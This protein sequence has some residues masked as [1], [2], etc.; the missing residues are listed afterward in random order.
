LILTEPP[1]AMGEISTANA[2]VDF[3]L[4]EPPRDKGEASS[5]ACCLAKRASRCSLI[6]RAKASPGSSYFVGTVAGFT[7]LASSL[8]G[9][10]LA[11]RF[12]GNFFFG[13]LTLHSSSSTDMLVSSA[14]DLN[15]T[16]VA[17]FKIGAF[18]AAGLSLTV[19][20]LDFVGANELSDLGSGIFLA[21]IIFSLSNC[22]V[23]RGLRLDFS[24]DATRCASAAWSMASMASSSSSRASTESSILETGLAGDRDVMIS[25]KES[26]SE[27][28]AAALS[29]AEAFSTSS[30]VF[31]ISLLVL[32]MT[33][34][35]FVLTT[36]G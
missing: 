36:S 2:L 27:L 29:T 22:L 24:G 26:S 28:E 12:K 5:L 8:G 20:N 23:V 34:S 18:G 14:A 11:G 6:L 1:R 33:A 13:S 30:S 32:G 25:T 17:L 9:R 35:S 19:A 31:D 7:A 3:T 4:T 21:L 16:D 10:R 15:V